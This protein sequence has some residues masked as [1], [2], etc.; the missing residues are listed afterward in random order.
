MNEYDD[1]KSD[2]LVTS[3][4]A[5]IMNKLDVQADEIALLKEKIKQMESK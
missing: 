1:G 3:N 2:Q 5:V 4:T